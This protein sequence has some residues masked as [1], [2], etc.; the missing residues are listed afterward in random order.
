MKRI[1][2]AAV[3]L[4]LVGAA[5]V[6]EPWTAFTNTTV[7]EPVPTV[8]APTISAPSPTP[9]EILPMELARGTF[10]SQEH[11]TSGTAQI[12]R[13]PD[14]SLTLRLEG[15]ETS[16]GPDL[17]VWLSDREAGGSWFKY[18]EGDRIELGELKANRGNHNYAIPADADLA[19]IQS[20]VIWCK[21]FQ[22]A[23]GS[24]KL[25]M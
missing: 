11:D 7:D 23:F 25:S 12:L 2:L 18:D 8:D 17:H 21:R 22:V 16:N 14:A 1:V 4:L 9:T 3:A 15:F 19:A 5:F 6:F 10:V 13:G 20:V 24:A